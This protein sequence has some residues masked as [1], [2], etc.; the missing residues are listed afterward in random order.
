MKKIEFTEEQ[1]AEIIRLYEDKS[2][3]ETALSIS[4]KYNCSDQTISKLLRQN[5]VK[6]KTL[7]EAVRKF[8]I[9][10]DKFSFIDEPEKAY[11]LGMLAGDGHISKRNEIILQLKVAD[12]NHLEKFLKFLESDH[13][14][15]Y[16]WHLKK[17]KINKSESY[18]ICISNKKMHSDLQKYFENNKTQNA[19]FP[20]IAQN[21]EKYFL[22]G[23]F[24]SDGSFFI[25]KTRYNTLGMNFVGTKDVVEKFQDIL[26]FYCGLNKTKI[27]KT[28]TDYIFYCQYAGNKQLLKIA[29]F[30]YDDNQLF[31]ERKKARCIKTLLNAYSDDLWLK[32]QA[33]T[34]DLNIKY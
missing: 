14:L 31:M 4:L 12:K 5:N 33:K 7:S 23:L 9:N 27:Q 20:K 22:L 19:K 32:E 30:F 34:V 11:W 24:D 26:S 21:L 17:D 16:T 18:K 13:N 1:K 2:I 29:K 3:N 28:R 25:Q 10:Q 15:Y 8:K 6:I